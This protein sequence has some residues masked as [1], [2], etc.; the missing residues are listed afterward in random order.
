MINNK[1]R[2]TGDF[3][4]LPAS[5]AV[6]AEWAEKCQALVA[7]GD[8]ACYLLSA[9]IL[10]T[11]AYAYASAIR[12]ADRSALASLIELLRAGQQPER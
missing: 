12:R 11:M 10:Y 8:K 9:S 2:I 7:P 1:L 5:G 6:A 4:P 3:G